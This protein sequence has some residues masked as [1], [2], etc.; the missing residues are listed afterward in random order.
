MRI[1]FILRNYLLII[2][3]F[4]GS[5]IIE[6]IPSV[7]LNTSYRRLTMTKYQ[8]PL[9]TVSSAYLDLK[10]EDNELVNYFNQINLQN[11]LPVFK[12]HYSKLG[13]QGCKR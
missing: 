7:L 3:L 10:N 6:R 12:K 11:I 4:Y 2:L 9:P 13:P 1:S 5:I 8:N